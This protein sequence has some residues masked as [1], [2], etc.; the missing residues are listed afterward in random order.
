MLRAPS[1]KPAAKGSWTKVS[2]EAKATLK[3]EHWDRLRE[4]RDWARDKDLKA[5]AALR[6]Q[7]S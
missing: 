7:G 3:K 1:R 5:D 4:L 2:L 6:K